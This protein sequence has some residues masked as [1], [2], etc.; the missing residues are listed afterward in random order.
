MNVDKALCISQ[1]CNLKVHRVEVTM[2]TRPHDSMDT[3]L[4]RSEH[5][6]IFRPCMWIQTVPHI[7]EFIPR[8]TLSIQGMWKTYSFGNY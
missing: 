7:R 4:C 2:A 6:S 1:T 8:G 3:R 5:L